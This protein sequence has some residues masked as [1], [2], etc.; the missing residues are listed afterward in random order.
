MLDMVKTD[1]DFIL[2]ANEVSRDIEYKK[3]KSEE[4]LK[5]KGILEF[6]DFQS[7]SFEGRIVV[8]KAVCFVSLEFEP[9][10]YDEIKTDDEIYKVVSFAKQGI[11]RYKLSLEMNKRPSNAHSQGRYR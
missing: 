1:F 9:S 10:I 4:T 3:Y 8:D 5:M 7:D 6:R 2:G 11:K